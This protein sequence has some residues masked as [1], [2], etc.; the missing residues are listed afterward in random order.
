LLTPT[1]RRLLPDPPRDL[2]WSDFRGVIHGIFSG[3]AEAHPER[4]CVVETRAGGAPER[5]FTYKQINEVSN[6]LGHLLV[7]SGIQRGDV[8]LIYSHRR[9][10]IV[11]AVMGISQSWRDILGS[12]SSLS[13]GQAKYLP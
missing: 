8:V 3:D 10:D 2:G 11:V 5:S 7:K 12:G 9:V 4:L 1:Q 6:I 13:S